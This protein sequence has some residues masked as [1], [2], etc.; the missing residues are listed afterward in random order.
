MIAAESGT[1]IGSDDE[2]SGSAAAAL[3]AVTAAENA[4]VENGDGHRGT[5]MDAEVADG[6]AKHRD[7]PAAGL[8]ARGL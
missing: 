8:M 3:S 7:Q 4:R 6:V 2:H 5:G 1:D